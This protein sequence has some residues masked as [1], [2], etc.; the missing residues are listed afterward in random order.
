MQFL[1]LPFR[2]AFFV[3]LSVDLSKF[4]FELVEAPEDVFDVLI[5][6]LFTVFHEILAVWLEPLFYCIS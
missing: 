2:R 6:I 3:D 1:H 5:H 4:V